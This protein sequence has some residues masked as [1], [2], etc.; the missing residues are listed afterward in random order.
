MTWGKSLLLAVPLILSGILAMPSPASAVTQI[1]S[2]GVW[3]TVT[4]GGEHSCAI[5]T[6]RS[7]YCSG[8]NSNGQVGDGTTTQRPSLKQ[9]GSSGVWATVTAGGTHTCAISTGRSLYCW[10]DNDD[11]Q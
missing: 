2:S 6:S 9:I 4:A 7:L 5:T 10:G 11:G 1:G 8:N 3:A